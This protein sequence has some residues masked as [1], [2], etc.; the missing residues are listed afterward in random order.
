MVNVNKKQTT[1]WSGPKLKFKETK[2]GERKYK[3][4]FKPVRLND[5]KYVKTINTK[6]LTW[7]QAQIRYPKMK[8]FGDADRDG[9]LNMFDC[10]P[11]DKKRHSKLLRKQIIDEIVPKDLS[12][13][14]YEVRHLKYYNPIIKVFEKN[15]DLIK[16]AKGTKFVID[17]IDVFSS[18]KAAYDR[19]TGTIIISPEYVSKA[20]RNPDATTHKR[21]LKKLKGIIKHELQHHAVEVDPNKKKLFKKWIKKLPIKD[22]YDESGTLIKKAEDIKKELNYMDPEDYEGQDKTIVKAL[23]EVPWKDRGWE[24][25]AEKFKKSKLARDIAKE[26]GEESPET[27]QSLKDE[28]KE[29]I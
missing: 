24:K 4:V 27:L 26:Y 23:N 2:K 14:K 28:L 20:L 10:K 11:F 7:P 13:D 3:P 6:H 21:D 18:G 25:D 12:E 19:E 22:Q 5:K 15:P 8:A 1:F 16:K 9:K 29:D 17:D